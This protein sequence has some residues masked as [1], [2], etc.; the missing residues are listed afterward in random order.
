MNLRRPA[1]LLVPLAF[2]C[3]DDE[4]AESISDGGGTDAPSEA[5]PDV[6]S[7]PPPVDPE[8]EALDGASPP[9]SG[10]C[11]SGAKCNG[12]TQH[13]CPDGYVAGGSTWQC[14]CPNG[15][16]TCIL[17]NDGALNFPVCDGHQLDGGDAA[18][19]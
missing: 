3:A 9:L 7:E 16:W 19:G 15:S 17:T 13:V 10:A 12:Y 6:V 11:I 5:L 8:C 1:W 18:D 4:R 14:I 2:A